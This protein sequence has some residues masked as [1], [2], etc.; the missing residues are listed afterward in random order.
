MRWV[1]R[2]H[3]T[4]GTPDEIIFQSWILRS[5]PRCSDTDP[6]CYADKLHCTPEDPPGCGQKDVPI[7]LP[8]NDLNIYSHT[9]LINEGLVILEHK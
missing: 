1:G 2:V 6:A 5:S 9:R 7:N 4:F 8:E 3:A